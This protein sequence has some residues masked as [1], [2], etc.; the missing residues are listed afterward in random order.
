M[1]GIRLVITIALKKEVPKDFFLSKGIPAHSLEALK[2][3]ALKGQARLNAGIL[4][5]TTGAGPDASAEAARWIL[6]NLMPLF[7][8]NIGTCGVMDRGQRLGEWLRPR[9]VMNESGEEIELDMRLPVPFDEKIVDVHSLLSISP[10]LAKGGRAPVAAKHCNGKWGIFE[11]TPPAPLFQRGGKYDAVDME[12]F[13]QAKVFSGSGVSFHCLKFG[14]DYSDD[15]T[16]RDFNEN[17]ALFT[18][19][20]ADIFSFSGDN[21]AGITVVI[22]VFNRPDTIKRS[23]DSVLSQSHMPDEIIIVDDCSD[24]ETRDVLKS[25][26]KKVTPVFLSRNSGPSRAR[27]EGVKRAN[28]EWIAFLDSD[29]CWEKDKLKNQVSYLKQ[30]PFYHILQSEEAWIRNGSRVNPCR[31]HKKPEGWIWG[32]SL[33]RCLVSPSGVLVKK[34]LLEKYGLFDEALPVCEDYDLWL[35]ISRHHPVGLEPS[36]SVIKYGGHEDQLSRRYPAMDRFRVKSLMR[37]L[38]QEAEVDY[39]ENI[40]RVLAK[41]LKILITGYEKRGKMTEAEECRE[42]LGAVRE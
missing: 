30:F 18:K 9:H 29:D 8:V 6:D 37:L 39:R 27:N 17:L 23:I 40:I 15:D 10:P 1:K 35:K 21:S 14:T 31:H 24:N 2:A 25:Y 34:T 38:K 12:C 42:M 4:V 11:I 5:L 41:K 36:L 33:E 7:V 16:R 32:P 19:K 26:G 28:S 13:S 20:M 22:P 3:G